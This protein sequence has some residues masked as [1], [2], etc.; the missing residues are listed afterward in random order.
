MTTYIR[1]FHY[2]DKKVAEDYAYNRFSSAEG[3]GEYEATKQVLARALESIPGAKRIFDAPCG[4]GRFVEFFHE[5]GYSY[6]G[7][8]I[9]ME[10]IEILVKEQKLWKAGPPLVR[11]DAEYLPFKDDIFDCVTTMRFLNHNIPSGIRENILKEMRRVS[12]KWLIVMAHRLKR[13]GPFVSLKVFIREL[14][15]GDVSKYRIRQEILRAGWKEENRIWIKNIK[16]YA[17][18]YI[19]VYQKI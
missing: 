6:F 14:F 2:Q 7:G 13:I 1:K 17:N 5:N 19:G 4:S 16:R 8:D 18:G 15:G 3:K 11:C 9:S 12:R 10:M